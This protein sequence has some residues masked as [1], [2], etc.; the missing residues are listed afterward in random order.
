MDRVHW[1]MRCIALHITGEVF[2]PLLT[3]LLRLLSVA[4]ASGSDGSPCHLVTL[5]PCHLLLGAIALYVLF[6]HRLDDRDLWS[7]HEARAGMDARSVLEGRGMPVPRLADGRLEL[8]KPPLYYWLVAGVAWVKGQL[9]G[10]S[11]RVDAWA[12][13]LPATLAALGCLLLL[14]ALAWACGRPGPGLYG[15]IILATA[16]HFTW[17]ARIGRIDMPLTL[18]VSLVLGGLYLA[19]GWVGWRAH[20]ARVVAYLALA[21]GIL[22]KGPIGAVLPAAGLAAHLLM[23][24]Q[25]P[26]FWEGGAW[27]SL[28]H[29]LGL[30]W[31]IPLVLG[32]TI[33]W[34]LWADAATAGRFSQEF[35]WLHNLQRGLG[36]SRLRSHPW[37]WYGPYFLGDFLP[38]SPLF[39]LALVL[40]WR[41]GSWQLDPLA[42]FGLAWF[43]GIFLVLSCCHFKRADYLL[44]AYPGAALFLACVSEQVV[45]S[46]VAGRL[47]RVV[48]PGLAACVVLGWLVRLEYVL[49]A[50]EPYR[51]YQR[52]A[53]AVRRQAPRPRQL[54]FFQ[55]EAHALA[56]HVG[57]PLAIRIYWT[58]LRRHIQASKVSHVVMPV[59]V[60]E[61]CPRRFGAVQLEEVVR[62]TDFSGGSHERPLVLVRA[63]RKM[64]R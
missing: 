11:P 16:F 6:F 4:D 9:G 47:A 31:G 51:D 39:L 53:A 34:F 24:R 64:T 2:S 48:I 58:D 37:W 56:F 8:Q 49:P 33:P 43:L 30:W 35:F 23:E 26:A 3:S 17:L 61:Q 38:W 18:T 12:V 21:A 55:T 14:G 1:Q 59:S 36:G 28:S 20:L 40:G 54:L 57:S 22:L 13:R 44:P 29:R 27:K 10:Q 50:Q 45:A 15:A 63:A 46:R 7:S 5:S 42:R 41:R 25:W 62:N 52:F 19:P 60:W 32:L